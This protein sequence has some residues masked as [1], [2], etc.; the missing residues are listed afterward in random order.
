MRILLTRAKFD[1]E[2]TAARLAELGHHSILSP[3]IEIVATGAALP[4]GPFDALIATSAHALTGGA[5]ALTNIPVYAVGER[6]R[7]AAERAGWSASI[8]VNGNAKALIADLRD[9]SPRAR[10][11]LYLAGRH[12][13]P[14]IEAAARDLGLD[15]AVIETYAACE[16]T[17]L[18]QGAEDALR[19]GEIDA[20]LH[21]SRRSAEIFIALAQ[22]AQ[23][24]PQAAKIRHFALSTDV[25]EPL[26][27]AGTQTHVSAHPDEDRLLA[28]LAEAARH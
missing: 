13:K 18:T 14:D 25:A 23:L 3:V 21:Y 6:T 7:E 17:A 4:D 5:R 19:K 10:R 28:A 20:A 22:G 9:H 26:R 27:A 16:A 15:L 24:W 8:H 12:R 2:R 11:A 1:A